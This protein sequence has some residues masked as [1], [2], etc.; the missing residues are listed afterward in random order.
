[1][2]SYSAKIKNKDIASTKP[3]QHNNLSLAFRQE[4]DATYTAYHLP[5]LQK[6]SGH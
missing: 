4:P 1:M 3:S 5:I 2:L 6:I